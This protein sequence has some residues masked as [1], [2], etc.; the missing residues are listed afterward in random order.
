MFSG[1][2]FG[3]WIFHPMPRCVGWNWPVDRFMRGMRQ[4]ISRCRNLLYSRAFDPLEAGQ[5][6]VWSP[7]RTLFRLLWNAGK[8]SATVPECL[9]LRIAVSWRSVCLKGTTAEVSAFSDSSKEPGKKKEV[10]SK[11]NLLILR[12]ES[13]IWTRDPFITSE[14]LYHWA[15]SAFDWKSIDYSLL[16][17]G[18]P[19]G[20]QQSVQQSLSA[21]T[22]WLM[23][24]GLFIVGCMRRGLYRDKLSQRGIFEPLCKVC[25]R[26]RLIAFVPVNK[27]S[28]TV[29]PRM[30]R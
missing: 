22:C 7:C 29:W 30:Y 12:A 8:L 26:K 23:I 6:C 16:K 14:V 4:R 28:S 2:I 9:V 18:N 13:E 24:S 25:P 15:N 27:K 5:C 11:C 17:D 1:L 3:M 19:C 10:A 21:I 20:V